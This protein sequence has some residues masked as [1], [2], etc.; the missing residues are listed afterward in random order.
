MVPDYSHRISKN[1]FIIIL[2][3]LFLFAYFY[4]TFWNTYN[5]QAIGKNI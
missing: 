5:S 3:F 1:I 4:Q 2:T